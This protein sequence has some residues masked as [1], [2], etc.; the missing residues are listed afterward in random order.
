MTRVANTDFQ[1]HTNT[2]T[3]TDVNTD[4]KTDCTQI[5]TDDFLEKFQT[6]LAPEKAFFVDIS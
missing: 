4:T 1:T 5:K 3:N 6:V 2:G